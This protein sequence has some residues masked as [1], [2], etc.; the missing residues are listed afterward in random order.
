MKSMGKYQHTMVGIG[1]EIK[2]L[3]CL[4]ELII[5]SILVKSVAKTSMLFNI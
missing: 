3:V 2:E 5:N 1:H 4:N